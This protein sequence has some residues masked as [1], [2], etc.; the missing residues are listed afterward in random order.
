[1]T[2]AYIPLSRDAISWYKD[3]W[4]CCWGRRLIYRDTH[5]LDTFFDAG[6]NNNFATVACSVISRWLWPILYLPVSGAVYM[7]SLHS[8]LLCFGS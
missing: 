4:W 6:G 5:L 3:Q 2:M 1:M 8:F 7:V